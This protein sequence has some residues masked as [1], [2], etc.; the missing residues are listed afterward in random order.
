MSLLTY[1]FD[2]QRYWIDAPKRGLAGLHSDTSLTRVADLRDWFHKPVWR[3][4]ALPPGV[5][6]PRARFVLFLDDI[7]DGPGEPLAQRLLGAGHEVVRVVRGPSFQNLGKHYAIN[8]AER[9]DY[10]ALL[11]ELRGA[12]FVAEHFVHLWLARGGERNPSADKVLE[13]AKVL[14]FYSLLFLAQALGQSDPE[15]A[16]RLSAVT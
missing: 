14:G 9:S 13:E 1:A 5:A 6:A 10:E 2:H 16:V 8:P 12:S 15:V 7:C 11:D 4:A 3:P